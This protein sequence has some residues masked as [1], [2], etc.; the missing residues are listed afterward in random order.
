[1]EDGLSLCRQHPYNGGW[2]WHGGH[3]KKIKMFH[4]K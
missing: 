2:V 4:H 3:G 1:M